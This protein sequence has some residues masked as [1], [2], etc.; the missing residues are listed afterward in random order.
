MNIDI[1]STVIIHYIYKKFAVKE[2]G[3]MKNMLTIMLV[4]LLTSIN[5][6][7]ISLND[8]GQ[9][10]KKVL[11]INDNYFEAEF[12][13]GNLYFSSVS[14]EEGDFTEVNFDGSNFTKELGSP[15]L[16]VFRDLFM[17]P[18]GSE[19]VV[20]IISGK[21]EEIFLD[22][23]NV[24]SRIIPAQPSYSKSSLPQDR[25]FV[26]NN[27]SYSTS[28]Y[29]TKNVVRTSKSG[30]MR[31]VSVGVLEIDP[32]SYDPVMNSL[33]VYT[34]L[35]IRISYSGAK[36]DIAKTRSEHFSPYFESAFADFINYTPQETKT[37][38]TSYPVTYLIAANEILQDNAK[39]EEFISWKTQKGFNVITQFFSSSATTSTVDTWIEDQYQ[40]LDP[41]PSFL[42]I[43]GD[44][45][46]TYVIPT[47]QNPPLGSAG[48]VSVSDLLYG[49]IG[50][51]SSTNRIPSIYVGRFSVNE[52]SELD[53][54]IDKTIWYE[55]GQFESETADLSYLSNVM[56]VAGVDASYSRSHGDPHISYGM[57][58]YFN[59]N[60]RMPLDG[61]KVN[62]TPIEYLSDTSSLYTTD[63]EVVSHV[64]NGVAFYN[65]TAHGY[66]GGFADPTFTISNVNSLENQGKYPLVI[67]NCCLT[68]SFRDTEC[69]GESWLNAADKG[70]V[71]FIGASM[72]TYW[73]E[74]LAMGVGLAASNQFPP[75]LD[76]L[77]PGM[78]DGNMRMNYPSQ[79]GL[80]HVGLLAVERLGTSMTSAY[81]SS[82]HLFGDP[83]LMIF[84]GIPGDNS[85]SHDPF[86][87]PGETYYTVH[88]L[89][90]SYVGITD[91]DGVLHGAGIADET[92]V[93]VI[94]ILPFSEGNAHITVTSQFKKPYFATIPVEQISGPYLVLNDHSLSSVSYGSSGTIDI[95]LKNI[96]AL[97]SEE[98]TANVSSGNEHI[99]FL[100]S[101]ENFE[102][103]ASGDSAKVTSAFSYTIS[104]NVTDGEKIRIDIEITDSSK[105][106]YTN[107]IILEAGAPKLVVEENIPYSITDPSD[108]AL[109]N[110]SITNSGSS[111]IANLKAILTEIN[112]LDI[113]ISD[114]VEIPE[115]ASGNTVNINFRFAWNPESLV[116]F[117]EVAR[118][119]LL[120]TGETGFVKNDSIDVVLGITDGFETGDFTHNE[121]LL[122]GDNPWTADDEN[123]YEGCY[124]AV[125]GDID[126]DQYSR[127][128]LSYNFSENS[129]VS[130]YFKIS[131]ESNYDFLYF[132]IDDTLKAKWS[133]EANWKEVSYEIP[134]GT[135]SLNWHYEKDSSV[136]SGL[137]CGWLDNIVISGVV[138][139][140][141]DN[142][143]YNGETILLGNYPNPFNP[144][145]DIKF[146]IN[147]EK[148]VNLSVYNVAGQLVKELVKGKLNA[149]LHI[150]KF[151]AAGFNSGMYF[152][153]LK[154]GNEKL[155]RKM[156]LVK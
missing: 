46:G 11:E 92:G 47:E 51:T 77:N 147:S 118:F 75:P 39:L 110:F 30:T 67:G 33:K 141:D 155:S 38:L 88:A 8:R 153:V 54:Q 26:I 3:Q 57:T 25:K 146:F 120:L 133:G 4:L 150:A 29:V 78:Y 130:F 121:W 53:A 84:M 31:G 90:N 128:S 66:N 79:A 55:K 42:L 19:P 129:T 35:K 132:Y 63:A 148:D 12:S 23:Y 71:G 58:Y 52:I 64:S 72:S 95:E 126:D 137:D 100:D 50:A 97:I 87:T 105:R 152:Y 117:A 115:I 124:S 125:S 134:A 68:G 14:T 24:Y 32:I 28:G 56:G 45:S 59:D 144:L 135:H 98:I 34:D 36:S 20:A 106:T 10:G 41:K 151:N 65:Y 40:N 76:T 112:G 6:G 13:L 60:Y 116:S 94:E 69:F 99:S 18:E 111:A 15:K 21:E 89:K 27:K 74:D 7:T 107:Y 140:K 44:Q 142:D 101:T 61:S 49:V 102:N 16:P 122:S 143:I 123:F 103:I 114:P 82:Y 96:G 83:S 104:P 81:W 62:I 2:A 113:S 80:K 73:D 22:D 93:A 1:V 86:M 139:D 136:S 109:I 43:I 9:N 85:V 108:I 145:T 131:S 138:E 5:A 149:G 37:D 70:A 48:S 127:L 91:D 17:Y 156:I 154:V 119:D